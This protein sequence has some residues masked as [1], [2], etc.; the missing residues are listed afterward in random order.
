MKQTATY[1]TKHDLIQQSFFNLRVIK[2]MITTKCECFV[3][4]ITTVPMWFVIKYYGTLL[5]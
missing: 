4:N 3:L 1:N 2:Y 5:Y